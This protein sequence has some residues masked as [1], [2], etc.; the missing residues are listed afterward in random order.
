MKRKITL[1]ALAAAVLTSAGGCNFSDFGT[2]DMLRPP[3]TMGEEAEIESLISQTAPDGY[4]LKYPKNGNHRSAIIMQ[5]LDNDDNDEAIAFFREKDSVAGIHM[6]VMYEDGGEW[7]ISDDF[8]TETTD[9]DSVEFANI[10]DSEMLEIVVGY[11][12]YTPNVNFLS[13]YSYA[14]GKTAAINTGSQNYSAFYCG[15]LDSSGKNKVITLSLFSTENEAKA[16]MLEYNSSKKS[17]YA[18]ASVGMDPN[19]VKY[20]NVIFTDLSEN[21]KGIVVDGSYA[22]DELTTQVIYFNK[23][24]AVMRNPLNYKKPHNPTLRQSAVISTDFDNDMHAEIPIVSTLPYNKADSGVFPADKIIWNTIDVSSENLVAKQSVAVNY[25]FGYSIKLND[26]WLPDTV[27]ALKNQNGDIMTFY[28]WNKTKAESP[29]F[30]IRVFDI[31]DWDQGKSDDKYTLIYK[32]T[33]YAYTFINHDTD[34]DYSLSD[35]EI[36]TA[37]SVFS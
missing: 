24:L 29:L 15:N 4:I 8:I 27:T 19:V 10:D 18:K 11:A 30:E 1:C 26:K 9:I 16:T 37:F 32:D 23:Q 22:N 36:K 5:D 2:N 25:N 3:K 13:C 28:K 14:N 21:V 31:S 20:K 7:K 17:L 33:R 34:S 12:T 6:L 35:D